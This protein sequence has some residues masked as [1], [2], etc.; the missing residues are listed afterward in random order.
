MNF[1]KSLH[2]QERA[3]AL[4]APLTSQFHR[5]LQTEGA[6]GNAPQG[7]QSSTSDFTDFAMQYR[8]E[9][10]DVAESIRQVYCRILETHDN[11]I[12]SPCRILLQRAVAS[13]QEISVTINSMQTFIEPKTQKIYKAVTTLKGPSE[14]TPRGT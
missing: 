6:T 14:A 5:T 4:Q 1:C 8:H 12:T 9:L 7:I 10:T 11:A 2:I 3:L 13:Q